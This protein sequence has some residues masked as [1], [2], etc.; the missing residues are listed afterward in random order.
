MIAQ[1]L[2]MILLPALLAAAAAFDL[3]SFTIPNLLS[4]ALVLAFGFFGLAAHFSLTLFSLHLLAG[5]IA[6]V[7]G[8]V[9]FARSYIGGG[10]AKFFAAVALWL[11]LHDLLAYALVASLLGGLL[12]VTLLALRQ[13]PLPANLARRGWILKLHEKSSGIPYGV[14]LAAGALLIL[15]QAEILKL[16]ASV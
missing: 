9:L 10:D 4:L 2:L 13:L 1:S 16:A 3:A 12:T 11:G 6:L 14:A 7:L 5:L 15:P 8:F